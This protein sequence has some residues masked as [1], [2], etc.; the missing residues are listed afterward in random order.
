MSSSFAP[1]NLVAELPVRLRLDGPWDVTFTPGWGAP[2]RIELPKLI[3]WT[4]HEN[5]GV[6]N[7]SGCGGLR[8][9]I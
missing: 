2:E 6:R 1:T 7:Y 8:E 4:E 9:G 3:S 5:P